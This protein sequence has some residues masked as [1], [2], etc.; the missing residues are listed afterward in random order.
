LRRPTGCGLDT[1]SAQAQWLRTAGRVVAVKA[2]EVPMIVDSEAS[3][4]F[5]Q[6]AYD[7]DD[8]IAVFLKSYLSGSQLNT[9]R[10]LLLSDTVPNFFN[11]PN[12]FGN[13]KL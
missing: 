9:I 5:L 4:R 13:R 7:P 10:I 8:W 12:S 11:Q 3:V 6:I 2:L 1:A